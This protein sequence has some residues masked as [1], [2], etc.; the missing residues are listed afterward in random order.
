MTYIPAHL[1]TYTLQTDRQTDRS[2]IFMHGVGEMAPWLRAHTA[3][4]ENLSLVPNL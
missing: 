2:E 3:L 4:A 1:C